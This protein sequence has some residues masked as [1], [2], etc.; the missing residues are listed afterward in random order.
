MQ[1]LLLSHLAVHTLFLLLPCS[2]VLLCHHVTS[3]HNRATVSH[4][5]LV[6]DAISNHGREKVEKA[7][8]QM[9]ISLLHWSTSA[10]FINKK[11]CY[12]WYWPCLNLV[13][14]QCQ[15]LYF[16]THLL[17]ASP[18]QTSKSWH[19]GLF[20]NFLSSAQTSYGYHF[21]CILTSHVRTLFLYILTG[22]RVMA[23]VN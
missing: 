4:I 15:I 3:R 12:W 2:A 20:K 5:L 9:K 8:V 10:A 11:H 6:T 1:T 16:H 17:G 19:N 21:T 14:Y 7:G 23:I 22:C 13:F 18:I